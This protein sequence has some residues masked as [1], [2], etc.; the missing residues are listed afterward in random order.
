MFT[1]IRGYYD[2]GQVVLTETSPVETRTE[3]I[4]TFLT[5]ATNLTQKPKRE[6]GG[7]EGQVT[8]P[9]DFN[10]PLDDLINYM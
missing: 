7:L 9:E 3:V 2:H 8:L 1:T 4:V 10:E 6:L 5:E